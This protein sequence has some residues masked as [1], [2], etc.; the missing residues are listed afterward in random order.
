MTR[1]DLKAARRMALSRGFWRGMAAP[2]MIYSAFHLP[3][4]MRPKFQHVANPASQDGLRGDWKRVGGHIRDAVRA[5]A[6][7]HE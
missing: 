4:E 6:S 5:H 2:L 3:E 1:I 7:A